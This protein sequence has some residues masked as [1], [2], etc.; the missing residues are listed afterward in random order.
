MDSFTFLP[1]V[2]SSRQCFSGE[3]NGW[4]GSF[5]TA[6]QLEIVS[7]W[8]TQEELEGS[9]VDSGDGQESMEDV[10]ST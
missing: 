4:S 8:M 1:Y 10:V 6:F 7:R 5:F 2:Y 3:L 9:K